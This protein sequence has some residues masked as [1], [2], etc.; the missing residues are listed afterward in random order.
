MRIATLIFILGTLLFITPATAQ[1]D[2]LVKSNPSGNS[3]MNIPDELYQKCSDFF[4]LLIKD[5]V[6]S[7]FKKLL[8]KS[9]I[10]KKAEDL[11]E[12][13]KQTRRAIKLYGNISGY[14]AVSW[15]VASDSYIRLRYLGIHQDLPMRWIFTFYKSP[16]RGWIVS[17]VRLDDLTE[18][19]FSDE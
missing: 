3:G 2:G 8:A 18:R 16:K 7:A 6:N 12:L 5:D 15:E 19:F 1:E 14:E 13:K 11:E 9:P 17:N 10:V 4:D